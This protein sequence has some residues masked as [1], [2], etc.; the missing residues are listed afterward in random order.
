MAV[1]EAHP[2]AEELAAF[3][4]GALDDER[5]ASLEA[6]VA[7]CSSCQERAA[8]AP[9]DALVELL[10]NVHARTSR[11]ADT[12][13]EAAAQAQT[14]VPLSAVAETEAPMSAVALSAPA[15]SDCP[16]VADAL[17]QEL[18]RLPRYRVVRLLGLGRMGAVY[19][20]EHRVLQRPVALRVIKRA[21]TAN[22]AALERFHR[23]VRA[24]ARLSHP[25]IVTTY[26]AEDAG[27]THFLVMEYV[28]GTDLGRLVQE[29][30]R[31][32]VGRA[33]EYVRQAALGLQHAFE[34]GM[35]HRDLRPHNLML[36]TDGR[37]KI[38]DFGLAR[39][40]SEAASAAGATGTGM[41]LGT[42]DYLAPEQ[43][44]DPQHADIRSDNYSLGCTLYHLLAGRPPFPP[45][46]PTQKVMAHVEKKPQPLTELRFDIPEELMVVLER[47]MA[48]DPKQ[49]YQT[50]A[51]V[52]LALEPFANPR[53][54]AGSDTIAAPVVGA[55]PRRPRRR[56][57]VASLAALLLVGA[58]VAGVVVYRVQTD[59]GELVIETDNDD[60]EVLVSKGGEVVKIIDTKTGKHVT[61]NS[62][63]Y[64]LAL[65]DGQEGLKLSPG[66]MTLKRGETVLATITRGGKRGDAL[67][68]RPPAGKPPD[69]VV[70]WWRADGNARDSAGGNHGAL[71]GGVT[72]APGV[73]GRAF[74]LDG[75]T[76]YVEAPRSDL[77]GFGARDFSI[78]LWVQFLAANRSAVF[79][80]CDEGGGARN[81][82]FF[83]YGDGHLSLHI[84][85][86][87]GNGG[88]YAK[89]DFSPD[90][91]QWYHL[92]VTRSRG[93]FTIYVNGAPVASEKVDV[94]IP[95][96]DAPLTI[97][98][99]EGLGF[100]SGLIDEVA[101]YDR[102][103][104]PAE[105][106]TRRSA[107]ASAA[108]V[109]EEKVGEVRQFNAHSN[110]VK[111]V[112]FFKDGRRFASCGCDRTIRIWEVATGKQLA[113]LEGHTDVVDCLALS[114]DQRRLLSGGN[115]FT[116]RLWDVETGKQLDCLEN[117]G[118]VDSLA[119]SPD[120]RLALSGSHDSTVRLWDLKDRKEV[121]RFAGHT[122]PVER[123]VMSSDGR[124]AASAS[125]D[126]TVRLYDL[127]KREEI[128]CLSRDNGLMYAVALS[129]DGSLLLTGGHDTI[130]RLWDVKTL[131]ELRHFEGHTD[132][133]QSVTFSPDGGRALSAGKD[134]TVRL[135]DV[136][137]GQEL[138][139]FARHRGLVWL[140]A[141]SPDGR[142]ALSCGEDGAIRLWRLPDPPPAKENP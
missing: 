103:L 95:N 64:E 38:L 142:S 132:Y 63:D 79:I 141:F 91:D 1:A 124:R 108:R 33:C 4:L 135:W 113:R 29:R 37:V 133:V 59:K 34:Q 110:G 31:L 129:S 130:V 117:L 47:M 90:L 58:A 62:G 23:E 104:S 137:T 85:N 75:A 28:D 36:T 21:C 26:D 44:D 42:V 119:V 78:E 56:L 67:A 76:R 114:P 3:T 84:N 17:P 120:G 116:I 134:G 69:G 18:A 98:Q 126:R 138:H 43:A 16:E 105:V 65:K 32:P 45:G 128:A 8:V 82:W 11:G 10:R 81:K 20:A 74:R 72:F 115:D 100:F 131:K 46:T 87:N 97:G 71:K 92:A 109:P 66:K 12:L 68:E 101:I 139:C 52:A 13:V 77:W 25:N 99:A 136:S 15:A 48:N 86:A 118:R 70:A 9:G 123:M 19:E 83:A 53:R 57:L 61:L 51:E 125:W 121:H 94:I 14:P 7:A 30:G 60:V 88:F 96:P 40:A 6:H 111:A 35:V 89:A 127:V 93:T 39:F 50:P 49:R 2:S 55:S 122:A 102:A 73:A 80:G 140:V 112:V 107:L 27:E 5:Q 41:V 22:A 106:K 54:A 24:A